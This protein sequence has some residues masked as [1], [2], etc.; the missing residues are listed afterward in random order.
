MRSQPRVLVVDDQERWRK[1]LLKTLGHNGFQVDTAATIA[2]AMVCLRDNFYH[3]LV[4]DLRM[5][6]TDQDNAK[7]MDLLAW[8]SEQ[9]ISDATE[10]IL[11]SAYGTKQQMRT[12]FS[13]YRVA[14]FM[15]KSSF[16]NLEFVQRLQQIFV[17]QVRI[18]LT[19]PILWQ[20]IGRPAETVVNLEIGDERIKRDSSL[21]VRAAT[22]LEDLLC[23]L[24]HTAESIMVRPLMAGASV[25]WV[26]PFYAAGAGHPVVVKFGDFRKVDQEYRNFK[27]YV[28]PFISG[29]RNTTVLD[30]RRTPLLGG[31][32][33]SL[34]GTVSDRLEDFGSFYRKSDI[35][36]IK[37]VLDRLF[38]DTCGIWYANLGR[39]QPHDL[40]EDYQEQLGFTK[41]GLD[42][43]LGERLKNSVQG[44]AKLQFRS[45]SE[46]RRFSNPISALAGPTV[47][48][49]VHLSHPRRFE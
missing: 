45:L 48:H 47:A 6:D 12:A 19:L 2:E 20:E 10:I 34:M 46:D 7:G 26:Q 27:D 14:D 35:S 13:R 21:Q 40:T 32:I 49:Y 11:L 3:A 38:Y 23:R 41:N 18:N 4:L 44:K 25:L 29:G 33:Y 36:Q 17:D 31:I 43:T 16:D 24:F 39:L 8:L 42:R 1:L 15:D 5:D 9:G 37:L 28:Q 30:L 22:E